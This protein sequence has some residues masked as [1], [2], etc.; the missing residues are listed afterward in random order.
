MACFIV[1]EA[2]VNHSGS[3]EL[4]FKLIKATAKAGGGVGTIQSLFLANQLVAKT[5]ANKMEEAE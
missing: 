2:G 4:A 3:V 1:A 5:G